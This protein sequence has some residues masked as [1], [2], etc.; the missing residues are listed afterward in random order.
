MANLL[1]PSVVTAGFVVQHSVTYCLIFETARDSAQLGV[2]PGMESG[3]APAEALP[4]EEDE[5]EEGEI[6]EEHNT[7]VPQV[8]KRLSTISYVCSVLAVSI[9]WRA[10]S[11]SAFPIIASIRQAPQDA[12]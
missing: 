11:S 2:S 3:D 1:H 5:I 9:D 4:K 8:K 12:S 10:S 6:K 7:A